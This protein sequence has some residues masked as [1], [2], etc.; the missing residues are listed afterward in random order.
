MICP[1]KLRPYLGRWF[2]DL[3]CDVFRLRHAWEFRS[4]DY[5]GERRCKKC[6]DHQHY[7]G[8]QYPLRWLDGPLPGS[9]PE[10]RT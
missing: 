9:K 5:A 2:A 1:G 10:V 7:I 6:G 4:F 3:V 8:Q